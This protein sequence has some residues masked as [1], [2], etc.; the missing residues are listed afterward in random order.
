MNNP[1]ESEN[2]RPEGE[3]EAAAWAWRIDRGLSAEEQDALFDWLAIDPR[4]AEILNRQRRD[5]KR[6]D[7]LSAWRP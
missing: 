3:S 5:W 1:F 7:K 6:L 4:H 2:D